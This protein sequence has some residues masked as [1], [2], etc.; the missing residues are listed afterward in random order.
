LGLENVKISIKTMGYLKTMGT[1]VKPED[2]I[3]EVEDDIIE[4][5]DDTAWLV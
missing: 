3:I 4:F 5:G 1:R 2:D